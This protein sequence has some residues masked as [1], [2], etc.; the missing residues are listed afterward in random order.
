MAGSVLLLGSH[1]GEN[2]NQQARSRL[3][4][5][6][7]RM[8]PGS[9]SLCPAARSSDSVHAREVQTVRLAGCAWL[10]EQEQDVRQVPGA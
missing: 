9:R 2:A 5:L 4:I 8:S 10:P 6:A 7:S 3:Y 1:M